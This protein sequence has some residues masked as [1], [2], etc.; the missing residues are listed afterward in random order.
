MAKKHLTYKQAGVDIKKADSLVGQIKKM[1]G[2]TYRKEVLKDIGGFGGLF[3]F[4]KDNYKNPVLVSS[5]DGVGTKL[6]IATLANKHDT[7][8][9]DMVA[10][11]VNDILCCGAEPLFFLDY[12][13]CSKL[14]SAAY[15]DI[16]KGIVAGC[17]DAGCALVGGE[18]AEMPGMY[19]KG[20]YDLA[21]FC[22]GVVEKDEIID[23]SKIKIGDSII[24]LA[25]SGLHSN[26]FSL[27]RKVLKKKELILYSKELLKPTRI[28]V[29]PVLSLLKNSGIELKGVAHITGGAFYEKMKRIIP[30]G[31]NFQIQK[32][33]WRIPDIFKLIQNKG[34]IEDKEM[35][36]TFNTGVGMVVVVDNALAEK[37][38]EEFSRSGLKA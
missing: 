13:G 32:G 21:G 12:L 15:K 23:G 2:S 9:I 25:S 8:G 16:I 26:G 17:K 6:K 10:M 37:T 22:V 5:S 20:E 18:T 33:S 3:G 7:V 4:N 29:K 28:Y 24:G 30:K 27:V 38:I 35:F 1:V 34:S 31:A 19:Q 11:N 14:E 36:H